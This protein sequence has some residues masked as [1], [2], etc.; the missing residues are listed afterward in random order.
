MNK[1]LLIGV[2]VLA[3]VGVGAF[4]L[5]RKREKSAEAGSLDLESE[6]LG[7]GTTA[8]SAATEKAAAENEE[9]IDETLAA[10]STPKTRK[11]ARQ[12]RRGTR[13]EERQGRKQTRRDCR[14]EAKSKGL[15]RLSKE[16]RNFMK[17]CKAAG[18]I[19]A[20]FAGEEADFAFNGY[21]CFN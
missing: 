19:N 15:K 8:Q 12:E 18:G 6:T 5:L 1:N 7:G 9:P 21:S 4:F 16:R 11:E 17:D 2:G 10:P 13:K 20:D 3:V 14:D